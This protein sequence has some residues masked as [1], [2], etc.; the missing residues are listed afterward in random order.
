MKIKSCTFEVSATTL[1][2]CPRRPLPEFAFIGRSNVGK[3]S[4][5]NL[6]TGKR[7]LARVSE[8]PGKTRL[9]NFFTINDRWRLVDLPG[10]GFARVAKSERADFNVAVADYLETRE[11]LRHTFVL[12]DPR[13]PPQGVDREFIR[14]LASVAVPFSIIFTK[15]DKQSAAQNRAGIQRIHDDLLADLD[16]TPELFLSSAKTKAGRSE[17]LAFLTR[18]LDGRDAPAEPANDEAV[19][20][21]EPAS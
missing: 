1:S 5:I 2:S 20:T 11:T 6:L 3:S 14:W 12:L 19:A 9:L 4:L 17:I 18:V 7:D 21:S 10:Y 16:P 15:A 13:V 8:T